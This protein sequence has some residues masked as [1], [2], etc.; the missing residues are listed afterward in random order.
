VNKLLGCWDPGILRSWECCSIWKWCLLFRHWGCPLCSGGAPMSL[1]LLSQAPYDCFGTD[2]VF[3]SP[4]ILRSWACQGAGPWN[5]MLSLCLRWPRAGADWK[6]S[7]IT[8]NI[9]FTDYPISITSFHSICHGHF[10]P[11]LIY[12]LQVKHRNRKN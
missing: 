6:D 2:V 3:H 5:C 1:L 4:V 10:L 7:P 11:L 8:F 12:L 9:Y